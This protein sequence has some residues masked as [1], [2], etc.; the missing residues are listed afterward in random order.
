MRPRHRSASTPSTPPSP[1]PAW[2]LRSPPRPAAAR[3]PGR[4]HHPRR[5]AREPLPP[6][7]PHRPRPRPA[8]LAD[9]GGPALAACMGNPA[10][11]AMA[12]SSAPPARPK[13]LRDR[14]N[15]PRMTAHA[16][17]WIVAAADHDGPRRRHRPQDP[18]RPRIYYLKNDRTGQ[19][20]PR[21]ALRD[22]RPPRR[23]GL[24][25]HVPRLWTGPSACSHGAQLG[26]SPCPEIL[27]AQRRHLALVHQHDWW[28]VTTTI[29]DATRAIHAA[30]RGGTWI[31]GQQRRLRQLAPGT[32]PQAL[33]G[34]LNASP[35]Q[36]GN[37]S[38]H[39]AIE[40]AIYPDVVWLAARMLTRH[41]VRH[42]G[43]EAGQALVPAMGPEVPG[44][45]RVCGVSVALGLRRSETGRKAG[46][47]E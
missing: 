18:R 39:P 46:N 15:R 22:R 20:P 28:R 21:R 41:E 3:H 43:G 44:H 14:G 10:G 36:P 33:A 23:A 9:V 2:P 37:V 11:S 38:A 26:I 29:S 30:L 8:G 31:P 13:G 16:Q 5:T 47:R 4:V 45:R 19:R 35:R 42:R 25:R 32:W 7:R 17:C 24:D 6:G 27:R 1:S 34:V 40:I 12:S